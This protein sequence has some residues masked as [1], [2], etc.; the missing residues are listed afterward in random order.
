MTGEGTG[1]IGV[2]SGAE[3]VA[4]QKEAEVKGDEKDAKDVESVKQLRGK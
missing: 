2:L 4:I 1:K 3:N